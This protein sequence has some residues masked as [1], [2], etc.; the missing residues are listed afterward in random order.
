M[1]RHNRS[2]FMNQIYQAQ[3]VL[4]ALRKI[5]RAT[6]IQSKRIAKTSG[7]TIPQ[8]MVLRAI[9]SLGDVTVKR[10]SADV[11]LSQA[12][13]TTIL[14][15]LEAR[16]MVV[17]VRSERDKRIV[18]ARL[19]PQGQQILQSVPALLHE[20]FIDRFDRLPSAEQRQLV[21]TLS[22]L[23]RMMD[24]EGLDAAP[25]LDIAAATPQTLG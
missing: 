16:G 15:R 8:V 25:I 3:D 21:D 17:R 13:V 23:A 19:L 20:Q 6:D 5:I 9:G 7:L 1:R 14:N 12:T 18:N 2:V 11:S 22:Q 10:L 24:A 4:V